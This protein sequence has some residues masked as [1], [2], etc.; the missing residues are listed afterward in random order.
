MAENVFYSWQS[1]LPNRC[2]RGF[3]QR[4]LEL[5]IA[6]VERDADL[7]AAPRLD[8]DTAGVPG[9]PDISEVIFGKIDRASIFV[10]DVTLLPNSD[11]RPAPNPNVLV[12]LGYALKALGSHR[13]IMVV[14]SHFG[15]IEGLPFDLR[16]KRVLSYSLDPGAAATKEREA[17]RSKLGSALRLVFQVGLGAFRQQR[18]DGYASE[19]VDELISFFLLADGM[20]RR[21]LNPWFVYA[22][23]TFRARAK[24]FRELAM[25]PEAEELGVVEQLRLL[26][27]QIESIA[28]HV[29][30]LGRENWEE[31]LGKIALAAETAA[32]LKSVL[33]SRGRLD[34]ESVSAAV[35]QIAQSQR[36]LASL[37]ADA[38]EAMTG[39]DYPQ[40]WERIRDR[41]AEEGKK[42]LRLS[43]FALPPASVDIEKLRVIAKALHE[44]E[45]FEQ[46]VRGREEIDKCLEAVQSLGDKLAELPIART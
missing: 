1:D 20:E 3:I 36:V 28:T 31:Y 33:F 10:A 17:F 23:S 6:D 30:A 32:N 41:A 44:L 19:V 7:E 5:A 37:R 29:R 4:A 27:G 21:F 2:N 40:Q 34:A 39:Q 9:S 25:Q 22:Q 12:E 15:A 14:N 38:R 18:L 24:A 11:G 13:V 26:A 43:Y 35:S 8:Q 45:L 16:R 42:L 46:R